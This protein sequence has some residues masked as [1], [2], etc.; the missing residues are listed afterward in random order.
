MQKNRHLILAGCVD[1][2]IA[3]ARNASTALC[4]FIAKV[5]T[6]PL[7][8]I[9]FNKHATNSHNHLKHLYSNQPPAPERIPM[10]PLGSKVID[11]AGVKI[12]LK[13]LQRYH[14]I[15]DTANAN[16]GAMNHNSSMSTIP[17]TGNNEVQWILTENA[18]S[19]FR[20][21]HNRA[22]L[23]LA[24]LI[25]ASHEIVSYVVSLPG[26]LEI[27]KLSCSIYTEDG[28]QLHPGSSH[29]SSNDNGSVGSGK[30]NRRLN[31]THPNLPGIILTA[32][33][34]LQMENHQ[35]IRMKAQQQQQQL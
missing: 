4:E 7:P 24:S 30:G 17:A 31:S 15:F 13:F 14:Q 21:A 12:P 33:N 20:Y 10:N 35:Q 23:A 26:A 32:L 28:S 22:L 11:W 34:S 29:H 27:I 6:C 5:P 3:M 2:I 9:D 16:R 8:M 1:I 25:V 18:K 19:E